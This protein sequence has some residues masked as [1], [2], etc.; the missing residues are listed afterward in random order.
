M[1]YVIDDNNKLHFVN[2]SWHCPQWLLTFSFPLTTGKIIYRRCRHQKSLRKQEFTSLAEAHHSSPSNWITV[3]LFYSPSSIRSLML[4]V[5]ATTSSCC[6]SI[7]IMSAN[8]QLANS[9]ADAIRS[10]TENCRLILLQATFHL[11]QTACSTD[12]YQINNQAAK[13]TYFT[14]NV[15]TESSMTWPMLASDS[16][17]S[18]DHREIVSD[19]Q[20]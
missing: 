16:M 18:S 20:R 7:L 8:I 17:Y 4:A 5:P 13:H 6:I 19:H 10:M 15:S 12:C 2:D 3:T 1:F 11:R 9:C 14:G